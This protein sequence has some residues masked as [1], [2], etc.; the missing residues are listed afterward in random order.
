MVGLI[1]RTADDCFDGSNNPCTDMRLWLHGVPFSSCV[2]LLIRQK[3]KFGD[4][5]YEDYWLLRQSVSIENYYLPGCNEDEG[6]WGFGSDT[7]FVYRGKPI[8][9]LQKEDVISCY[10][11]QP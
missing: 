11:I 9:I 5:G 10:I 7:M 1:G 6:G 8:H 4:Y 3:C 2:E